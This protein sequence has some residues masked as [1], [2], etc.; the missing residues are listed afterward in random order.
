MKH[1]IAYA[2][3]AAGMASI[4][5]AAAIPR[6]Q[7]REPNRLPA[8]QIALR[9]EREAARHTNEVTVTFSPAASAGHAKKGNGK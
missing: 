6:N 7:R 9:K 5:L 2:T 4:A 8:R 1:S 3:L